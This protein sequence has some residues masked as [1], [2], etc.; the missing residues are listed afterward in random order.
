MRGEGGGRLEESVEQVSMLFMEPLPSCP[1]EPRVLF[2][3]SEP[4]LLWLLVVVTYVAGNVLAN[5]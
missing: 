2:L 1:L 5:K 3:P 4:A